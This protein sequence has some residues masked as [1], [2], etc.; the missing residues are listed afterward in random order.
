MTRIPP[1]IVIS[2]SQ[3]Y[4][5]NITGFLKDIILIPSESCQE[6]EV[7]E[8]I[9]KEMD[10]VGFDEVLVDDM[11]S[12]IGIL[13]DGPKTLLYDSHID[14]VGVGDISAWNHDPYTG[15]TENGIV[16]GRG[17]SDNKGAMASMLYGMRV[18]KDLDIFP[19]MRLMIVGIVQEESCEGLAIKNVCEKTRMPDYVLLGECTDLNIYRGHRGR[20]EYSITT[21]GKACHASAPERGVNAI[22]NMAQIICGIKELNKKLQLDPFLGKGTIVVTNIECKTPSLNAVPDMCR[23][24]IDRR[25]TVGENKALS[26]RELQNIIAEVGVKADVKVLR[27]KE[28]CYTGLEVEVE[29]YYPTWVL[30]EG[31]HLV[32]SGIETYE[33]LFGKKPEVSR[34][35]FSTDGVYTMGKVGIPTIGFG[36]S[37]EVFTHSVDDQVPVAHLVKSSAFYALFPYILSEK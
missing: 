1:K 31:H 15:K 2:T 22:N 27:Y 20:I 9:A 23:I 3:A 25:L 26:L 32:L 28:K 30:D 21:Y 35:L 14:T 7:I 34:W 18:L 10:W 11:G 36:P 16:Y 29:K 6:S 17:A 13:G 12:V 19:E 5:D 8:R 24:Y 37:S 4:K 33:S